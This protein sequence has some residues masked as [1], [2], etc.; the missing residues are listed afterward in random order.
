MTQL[1]SYSTRKVI[2]YFLDM[3]EKT[4]PKEIPLL[5]SWHFFASWETYT[6]RFPLI[7]LK[8]NAYEFKN[9]SQK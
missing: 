2:T 5:S 7:A 3:F 6:F 9:C 1:T 4:P 8:G